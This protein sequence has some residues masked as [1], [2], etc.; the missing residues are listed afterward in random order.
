MS[1][2]IKHHHARASQELAQPIVKA[3]TDDSSV[4]EHGCSPITGK[5]C[6]EIVS[7]TYDATKKTIPQYDTQAFKNHLVD[8]VDFIKE[9]YP[10]F[11][12]VDASKSD[13]KI[14]GK[15]NAEVVTKAHVFDKGFHELATK[16]E[17]ITGINAHDVEANKAYFRE[18]GRQVKCHVT[19]KHHEIADGNIDEADKV[20]YKHCDTVSE[21]DF[22]ELSTYGGEETDD[23]FMEVREKAADEDAAK[24]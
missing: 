7:H 8:L 12:E 17:E 24:F 2:H 19:K 3:F 9:H 23:P 5:I 1:P 14:I 11:A 22:S 21:N 15:K 16:F 6:D 20:A 4:G 18:L 10:H 13:K